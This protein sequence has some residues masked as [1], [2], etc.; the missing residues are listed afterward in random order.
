MN[1]PLGRASCQPWQAGRCSTVSTLSRA[2]SPKGQAQQQRRERLELQL[3]ARGCQSPEQQADRII[4]GG[5][6]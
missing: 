1:L 3:I 2:A 6:R 4:R 5:D